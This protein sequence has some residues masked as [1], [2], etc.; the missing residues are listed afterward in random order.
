ME[1]TGDVIVI[2]AGLAGLA[3]A[4]AL[5]EFGFSVTVL[6][7]SDRVGGRAG[8]YSIDGF[9]CDSGVQWFDA[10]SMVI[11]AAV[12]VAALQPQAW[13]Q[14][15]VLADPGS[16]WLLRP[17]QLAFVSAI[18]NGIGSQADIARLIRWSDPMRHG[19]DRILTLEDM[20]LSN[21]FAIHGL[22]GRLVDDVLLPAAHII[23]GDQGGDSS[24]QYA[25]LMWSR[26][27]KGASSLPMLGMQALPDLMS[28]NLNASVHTGVPV[29]SVVRTPKEQPR[30]QI[31]SGELTAK[32]VVVA[33]D[34][35]AASALVGTGI[36][37]SRSQTTWWYAAQEAP[38]TQR[39]V[40][41][42]PGE[43]AGPIGH[44]AV[45]SNVAARYAPNGQA[46]IG[47]VSRPGASGADATDSM[48][49]SQLSMMFQTSTRGWQL[50]RVSEV[51][52]AAMVVTPP[53]VTKRDV[54]L[55]DGIYVA[56]DHRDL[57]GFEGAIRS[58]HRAADAIIAQL[59]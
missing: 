58:G 46:L 1:E 10:R 5:E 13:D 36:R 14:A 8:G 43:V 57:P 29:Q 34:T 49:R 19:E 21:S 38:T 39:C 23:L 33:T 24:F 35:R 54:D 20:T 18:R 56:G 12:D 53:L 55:G 2:G 7:A 17:P 51:E 50:L 47:A 11:R 6:E 41:V 40:F 4:H 37:Q 15:M 52:D 26:F 27:L 30:V 16:F 28:R 59:G 9:R 22:N 45:V 3:C 48:L 25:M 31:D 32:A 42:A 44:A